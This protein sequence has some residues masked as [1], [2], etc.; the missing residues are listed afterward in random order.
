MCLQTKPIFNGVIKSDVFQKPMAEVLKNG[1]VFLNRFVTGL[2][3]LKIPKNFASS[4][5][6]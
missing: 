1:K 3:N 4:I 2:L 6:E 5:S